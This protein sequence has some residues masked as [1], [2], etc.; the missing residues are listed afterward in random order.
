MIRIRRLVL[1]HLN[2][3]LG[4]INILMFICGYS[5]L[6]SLSFSIFSLFFRLCSTFFFLF[7]LFSFFFSFLPIGCP[8]LF[9]CCFPYFL[10]LLF[11]ISVICLPLSRLLLSR[12]SSG[13]PHRRS[14]RTSRSHCVAAIGD[15]LVLCVYVCVSWRRRDRTLAHFRTHL[16][17]D[18][19][20][21][22]K[23]KA[24]STNICLSRFSASCSVYFFKL[25]SLGSLSGRLRVLRVRANRTLD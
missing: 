12:F 13:R 23:W 25:F 6:I 4:K 14:S 9:Y 10:L 24:I 7:L 2:C 5:V 15:L 17:N 1:V 3:W 8:G 11:V 20:F 21:G 22:L 18:I 19:R 16:P